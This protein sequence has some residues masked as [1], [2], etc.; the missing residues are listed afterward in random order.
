M[1]LS[2]LAL[3]A[4]VQLPNACLAGAGLYLAV[5]IGTR[6]AVLVASS[7]CLTLL[8]SVAGNFIPNSMRTVFDESGQIAGAIDTNTD[9]YLWL[10]YVGTGLRIFLALGLVMLAAEWRRASAVAVSPNTSFERTRGE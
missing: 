10:S 5:K 7:L 2:D 3:L 8:L 4:L 9:P 1:R 6:G